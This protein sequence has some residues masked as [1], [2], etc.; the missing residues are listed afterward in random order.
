M[1]QTLD[2]LSKFIFIA[3]GIYVAIKLLR[4]IRVV[5][6]MTALIVERLGKYHRTLQPGFHILVPF[7]DKVA[8]SRDLKEEAMTVEPQSC[9]TRDNVKVEVDGIIYMSVID[10]V[11]A[12]YGI[13]DYRMAAIQLTQTTTRSVIGTIDLDKTFEERDLINA[14]VVKTLGEAA[15]GWGMKV[16]R[17]EVKNIV[18]PTSVKNA[19]EKM[20]TAERDRRAMISRAQGHKQAKI[21]D[22]EGKLR[23]LVNL[24]EGEKM[25]RINE[26]E[27]RA[28]EIEAI[29]E[30]TAESIAKIA[31]AISLP[32]GDEA[33]R[34]RLAQ[35]QLGNL[36]HVAQ[37]GTRVILPLD[38]TNMQ[39]TLE[40]LALESFKKK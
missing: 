5:P 22:S 12:S 33:I 20:M 27:G 15:A 18:P 3:L 4:S 7:L 11:A 37:K 31:N 24:S 1:L 32:N 34:M 38:I 28:R 30:A 25:K 13:T 35:Q 9:F 16:H 40:G 39:Q 23:E 19:M 8:F 36:M 26:A 17:Y 29:A 10:P 2:I 6:N 14:T 21:N